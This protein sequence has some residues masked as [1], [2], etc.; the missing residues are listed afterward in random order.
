[1]LIEET[2]SYIEKGLTESDKTALINLINNVLKSKKKTFNWNECLNFI[3]ESD[4]ESKLSSFED[5]AI[6]TKIGSS[7]PVK[8]KFNIEL[9]NNIKVFLEEL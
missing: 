5:L 8:L 7:M 1:M 6:Y 9:I 2:K 3:K 4:K